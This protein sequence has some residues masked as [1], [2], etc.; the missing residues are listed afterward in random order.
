[1]EASDILPLLLLPQLVSLQLKVS[2]QLD[3]GHLLPT[4]GRNL[5]NIVFIDK[6]RNLNIYKSTQQLKDTRL[7]SLFLLFF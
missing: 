4:Q 7:L 2:Y 1:M 5:T 6:M 3:S